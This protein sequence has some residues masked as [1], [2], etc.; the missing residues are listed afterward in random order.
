MNIKEL[1]KT[2]ME[3]Q[4]NMME[5]GMITEMMEETLEQD[6]DIDEDAD[7]IIDGLVKAID[8]GTYDASKVIFCV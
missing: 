1:Q 3:M 2:G 5:M 8:K 7:D 4:R 6:S